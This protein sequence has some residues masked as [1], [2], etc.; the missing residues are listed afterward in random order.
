LELILT[1]FYTA[2]FL[3]VIKK[4]P[5][6]NLEGYTYQPVK[7]VFLLK[8]FSGIILWI[9]Y[10]YYYTDRATSDIYKF[11]DDA[12]HIYGA[13]PQHPLYYL[14][15]VLGINTDAEYLKPYYEQM[16]HW[17]APWAGAYFHDNSIIIQLN[18]F[19]YLFSFG[20]Y[21]V[22]TVFMC[23]IALCGQVALYKTFYP[24]MPEKR[25]ALLIAVFLIPSVLFW[26]SGVLKESIIVFSL[27]MLLYHLFKSLNS[28]HYKHFL[29]FILFFILLL[30][31]KMYV[32]A[33]LLPT[34]VSLFAVKIFRKNVPLTFIVVHV[35]L[36]AIG[37]NTYF[38]HEEGD[39]IWFLHQKQQGFIHTAIALKAGSY[40]DINYLEPNIWSLLKNTPQAIFNTLFRPHL[41]DS[42]SI[43]ILMAAI[44]NTILV[45]LIM[46]AI[47]YFKK[48]KPEMK[49]YI[50]AAIFFTITL[51]TLIGLL[52]PVLGSITRYRVPVTSL[53][54]IVVF[55]FIDDDKTKKHLAFL[56]HLKIRLLSAI[57]AL[58]IPF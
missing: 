7:I 11:Y 38:I 54:F 36:F 20:Y 39:V 8:I 19:I 35:I 16:N 46:M 44:E 41:L 22:H 37:T 45:V 57:K 5:F 24:I 6:F 52:N 1:L 40:F 26:S 49:Q 25:D 17:Y 53:C 14:Q 30:F 27:G 50:Y 15:M 3:I 43:L 31:A 21:Q 51:S 32:F 29:L 2:L 58:K 4:L 42:K 56:N 23:F 12:K 48:P 18:A 55:I 34:I 47:I 13:L 28:G 9:I 10:T 33:A